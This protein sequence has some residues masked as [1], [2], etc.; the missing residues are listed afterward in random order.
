MDTRR[1]LRKVVRNLLDYVV[2]SEI[3]ANDKREV[4]R[5]TNIYVLA[6]PQTPPELLASIK[7]LL[8]KCLAG[9]KPKQQVLIRG[10]SGIRMPS[11]ISSLSWDYSGSRLT[12]TSIT[13]HTLDGD[14]DT[15]TSLSISFS[16]AMNCDPI[17][18]VSPTW[19]KSP[20]YKILKG[21]HAL[22]T[23]ITPG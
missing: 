22:L 19:R 13:C 16:R 23:D 2:Q 7:Q 4:E 8:V 6:G 9:A 10:V 3:I 21:S 12:H 15:Y 14:A 17:N 18:L 5:G 11:D 1:Q 20:N